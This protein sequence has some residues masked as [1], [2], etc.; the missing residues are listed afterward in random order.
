MLSAGSSF[1]ARTLAGPK[2][3]VAS[4][5][6]AF[7]RRHMLENRYLALAAKPRGSELAYGH[8]EWR[9]QRLGGVVGVPL[10][11]GIPMFEDG[12]EELVGSNRRLQN[13]LKI[14]GEAG[15]YATVRGWRHSTRV[16]AKRSVPVSN[17]GRNSALKCVNNAGASRWPVGEIHWAGK[18]YRLDGIRGRG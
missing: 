17:N 4:Q 16:R 13:S 12:F 6:L 9:G 1:A 7:P 15:T 5:D 10:L 3:L 2:S 11:G 18:R 8:D 14:G